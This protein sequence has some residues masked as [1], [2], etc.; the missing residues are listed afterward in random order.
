MTD[1]IRTTRRR[2]DRHRKRAVGIRALPPWLLL[3]AILV[4]AALFGGARL[5]K[6][7]LFAASAGRESNRPAAASGTSVTPTASSASTAPATSPGSTNASDSASS[8]TSTGSATSAEASSSAASPSTS[9]AYVKAAAL[10]W[11]NPPSIPVQKSISQLRPRHKLIAITLDDGIPF[12][13]RLL[14]L[15]EQHHVRAT[16]FLLG[17]FAAKHPE[18]IRRLNKDGFEIASHAWDHP[19]LTHLSDS[20]VRS[21]LSRTQ[22][23][24]SSIT[25]NQAPY[26]RP[27]YGDTNL[28]IKTIAASMGYRIVL[29][30]R[31]FADTSPSATPKQLYKNVV[32][33]LTPGDVILCHWGQR[34][35]YAAMKLILPELEREGFQIVTISE[36]V[37]D[38]K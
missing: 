7:G 5:L 33:G 35:T 4:F 11:P 19:F 18:I 1:E 30:N 6:G 20:A 36:L 12:D 15:L 27:P 28:R 10:P 22:K 21:Q 14:A 13:M 31:T 37:A 2:A 23:A 29:W 32:N 16:T 25:G 34:D 38:S 8:S 3:A 17:Q 24:I 26:L 9:A